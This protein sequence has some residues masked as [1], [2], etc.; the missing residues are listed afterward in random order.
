[1]DP[2]VNSVCLGQL[3]V[4]TTTSGKLRLH[5][6]Y[7]QNRSF[8]YATKKLWHDEAR[9]LSC[10]LLPNQCKLFE[11]CHLWWLINLYQAWKQVDVK[12]PSGKA[13]FRTDEEENVEMTRVVIFKM[14]INVNTHSLDLTANVPLNKI[15]WILCLLCVHFSLNQLA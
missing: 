1:M 13:F 12:L 2:I 5:R 4:T 11:G 9:L 3:Q 6:H 14:S 15:V 10:L 7:Y 8:L